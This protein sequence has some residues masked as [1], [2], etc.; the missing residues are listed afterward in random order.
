M[1][2]QSD[3][4]I[5]EVEIWDLCLPMAHMYVQCTCAQLAGYIHLMTPQLEVLNPLGHANFDHSRI[6]VIFPFIAVGM[7]FG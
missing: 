2:L 1:P 4:L 7:M 6:E 3:S 5:V